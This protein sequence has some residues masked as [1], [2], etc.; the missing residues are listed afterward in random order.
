MRKAGIL[1]DEYYLKHCVADRPLRVGLAQK[2]YPFIPNPLEGVPMPKYLPVAQRGYNLGQVAHDISK[3][4]GR[5]YDAVL[6]LLEEKS[7]KLEIKGLGNVNTI[8]DPYYNNQASLLAKKIKPRETDFKQLGRAYI[9]P[10]TGS[11]MPKTGRLPQ[12]PLEPIDVGA[13]EPIEEGANTTGM[14]QV[15]ATPYTGPPVKDEP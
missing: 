11:V 1:S 9:S 8:V 3:R 13:G 12:E 15:E 14:T 7:R 6:D 10:V 2:M 5:N 4:T